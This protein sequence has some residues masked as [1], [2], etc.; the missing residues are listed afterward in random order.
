M[1]LRLRPLPESASRILDEL[2]APPRLVAHLTL[3][4]DVALGL[5]SALRKR[6]PRLSVDAEAVALGAALHDIGKAV[7]REELSQPGDKHEALGEQLLLS[8][9]VPAPIARFARTHAQADREGLALEDLLVTL[10]D[11]VWKGK[12]DEP[13]EQEVCR[14]VASACGQAPWEVFLSLDE[15]LERLARDADERLE[16]QAAHGL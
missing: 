4:H 3:V 11:K 7:V 12:R 8:R 15:V 5:I 1:S 16:W 13:L 6:W 2:R 9:G 10:A 14:R